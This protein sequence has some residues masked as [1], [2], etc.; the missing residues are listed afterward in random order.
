MA[1]QE[2]DLTVAPCELRRYFPDYAKRLRAG[3][4]FA[5]CRRDIVHPV[6]VTASDCAKCI[7]G[8]PPADPTPEEIYAA[9][10][11]GLMLLG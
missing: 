6:K 10:F 2:I 8:H 9:F 3:E 5:T 7:A 11:E 4:K 1:S